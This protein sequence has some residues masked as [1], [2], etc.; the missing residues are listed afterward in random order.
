M[1]NEF[2]VCTDHTPKSNSEDLNLPTHTMD[3]VLGLHP[4]DPGLILRI[5]ESFSENLGRNYLMLQR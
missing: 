4:V 1:S 5:P 3:S 2:L